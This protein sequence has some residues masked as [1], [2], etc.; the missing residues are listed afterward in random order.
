VIFLLT[1][2]LQ[3]ILHRVIIRLQ[4][5]KV[6]KQENY[7]ERPGGERVLDTSTSSKALKQRFL[8]GR[9]KKAT[10]KQWD[11]EKGIEEDGDL[12]DRPSWARD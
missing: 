1:F 7:N 9:P 2:S 11:V 10:Q 6:K 8:P 12:C 4:G 5:Q 3:S